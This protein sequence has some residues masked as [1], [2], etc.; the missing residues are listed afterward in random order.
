[1]NIVIWNCR[2]ALKPSFQKHV[3]DLVALHD[4]AIFVVMETHI[5]GDRAKDITDR[6]P[7][8]GWRLPIWLAQSKKSMFLSR[9]AP[10]STAN[11]PYLSVSDVQTFSLSVL[12]DEIRNAL[13]ESKVPA[14]LNQTHI[15]LILKIKGPETIGNYRPISLCNSVYK[16]ISKIIVTRIRPYLDKLVSPFQTAFVPGRK[17][18]DNAIIA[19]EIIHTVGR[20]RGTVGNM[21][22]KIDLE[23]AYDRLEWSFLRDVLQAANFP[24]DMV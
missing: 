1:M 9:H 16:I 4:P 17:G 12:D 8:Q 7:F 11:P 10:P 14:Y 6:L 24:S 21:V 22:I 5:G 23:K 20:K 15:A 3:R 18:L 2:G 13:C 19:Q